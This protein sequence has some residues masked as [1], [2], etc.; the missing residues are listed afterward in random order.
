MKNYHN[1]HSSYSLAHMDNLEPSFVTKNQKLKSVRS[2]KSLNKAD[3]YIA[4]E[5]VD[6]FTKRKNVS[7]LI[8]PKR[9]KSQKNRQS[10]DLKQF[11]SGDKPHAG[12]HRL[13]NIGFKSVRF[14]SSKAKG[15]VGKVKPR[16]SCSGRKGINN[17]YRPII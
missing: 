8:L 17:A 16:V 14:Y 5:L 4:Y 11:M 12:R 7:S 15:L 9:V 2:A 3:K 6:R 13:P 10:K 1:P